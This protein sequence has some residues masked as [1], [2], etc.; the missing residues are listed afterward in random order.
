MS[1]A[2]PRVHSELAAAATAVAS[3]HLTAADA[4]VAAR[5]AGGGARDVDEAVAAADD[6]A[7][8][9]WLRAAAAFAALAAAFTDV[10][11]AAES[12]LSS[13]ARVG[14][15][16]G[17]GTSTSGTTAL[18][19]VVDG[20]SERRA[21]TGG[22]SAGG[23]RDA[24]VDFASSTRVASAADEGAP[25]DASAAYR[26][27][28][29]LLRR[30]VEGHASA[31]ALAGAL[32]ARLRPRSR[33]GGAEGAAAGGGRVRAL[34]SFPGARGGLPAA[35]AGDREALLQGVGLLATP[36]YATQRWAAELLDGVACAV[37]LV[38]SP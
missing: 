11:A 33:G 28:G 19:D 37:A 10:K 6:A 32:V 20:A 12:V 8:H 7:S 24:R 34:P 23:D 36:P 1:D 29:E 21:A 9:A 25:P 30:L 5:V 31:L 4:G 14:D 3:A 13:L 2:W 22:T 35:V 16:A 15:G 17:V 26:A 18:S 27:V 38:E